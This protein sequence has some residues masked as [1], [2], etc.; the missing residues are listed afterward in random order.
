MLIYFVRHGESEG[1]KGGFHHHP[2][3]PLSE[4]GIK[5]AEV[6]AKRLSG[7]H[8]DKIYSSTQL[9]ARQTAEIINRELK[10]PIDFLDKLS[11]KRT[12][13]EIHGKKLDDKEISEIKRVIRDKFTQGNFRYSDEETPNEIMER[14][15]EIL[16]YLETKHPNDTILCVTHCTFIKMLVAKVIFGDKLTPQLF[17]DLTDR[18]WI[19]NTGITI[20]E[21]SVKYGWT[22]NTWNDVNH[23]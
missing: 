12:P 4:T 6:L 9:R 2:E 13:T 3:T 17:L 8:F 11:E 21:K 10:T 20:C 22:L 19:Q 15:G 14:A 23:L 18:I 7:I 5:Q 16:K 1:N